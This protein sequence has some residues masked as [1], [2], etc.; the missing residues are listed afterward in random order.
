MM[1][2]INSFFGKLLTFF[3]SFTGS[4]LVA[5]LLFAL[6]VKLLLLPFGIK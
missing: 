3:N 5:I 6:L 2:A 4:Y 1:D